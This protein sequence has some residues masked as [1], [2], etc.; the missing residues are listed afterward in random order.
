[1]KVFLAYS[2]A[3]GEAARTIRTMLEQNGYVVAE[4]NDAVATHD[5]AAWITQEIR[6][7]DLVVALNPRSPNLYF[8]LG[9]AEGAGA[10]IL[11]AADRDSLPFDVSSMPFVQ[12]RGESVQWADEILRRIQ[13]MPL[14][15]KDRATDSTATAR[16]A[17]RRALAEPALLGEWTGSELEAQLIRL[18]QELG[19]EPIE[20]AASA[21]SGVD[22]LIP[23]RGNDPVVMV[24]VKKLGPQRR[25][26]I[27]EVQRLLLEVV[28]SPLPAMGLMITTGAYTSAAMDLAHGAPVALRSLRDVVD[29]RTVDELI[30][31]TSRVVTP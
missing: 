18:F 24:A 29:A 19:S 25:V 20:P 22:F 16:G 11:I 26:S 5:L 21:T 3:D 17:I 15:P 6:R 31:R 10:A 9:V 27:A 7:A 14:I 13:G 12:L 30:S 28:G 4:S 8:E 2:H 23:R 1:M